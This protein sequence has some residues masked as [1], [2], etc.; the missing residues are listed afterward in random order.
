ML[1]GKYNYTIYYN[2]RLENRRKLFR[3]SALVNF[4]TLERGAIILV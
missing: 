2:L 4:F 3:E 1:I